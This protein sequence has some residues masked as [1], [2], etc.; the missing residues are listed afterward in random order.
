MYL[1]YYLFNNFNCLKNAKWNL[2][3]NGKNNLQLFLSE[4]IN[5]G[6]QDYAFKCFFFFLWRHVG[7]R[8]HPQN[9]HLAD[10]L[11]NYRTKTL[12]KVMGRP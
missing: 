7:V 3:E 9:G 4:I 10:H 11:R 2:A 12:T 8:A 1:F 5:D 6:K